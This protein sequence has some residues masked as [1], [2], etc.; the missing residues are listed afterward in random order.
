MTL[1]TDAASMEL[2]TMGRSITDALLQWDAASV[3]FLSDAAPIMLPVLNASMVIL[4]SR[5]PWPTGNKIRDGKFDFGYCTVQCGIDTATV[6][7]FLSSM[8]FS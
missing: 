5:G 8:F 3:I 1:S 2:L 4:R 6:T 7:P